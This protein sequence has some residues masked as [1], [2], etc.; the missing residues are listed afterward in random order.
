MNADQTKEFWRKSFTL[1]GKLYYPNL[2]KPTTNKNGRSTFNTMLAW[3]YD[4][5]KETMAALNNFL[6]T[7]KQTFHPSAPMQFFINPLKKFDTYQR[8]DGK[9]NA[10]YLRNCFWINAQSGAEI[11]VP[12]V[13]MNRQPVISEAEVYS[14]RN[15]VVNI[16]FYNIDKEKKGIGVNLNAVMLMPGG[17]RVGGGGSVNIDKIFG[18]FASDMAIPGNS[19]PPP[20]PGAG[21]NNPFGANGGGFI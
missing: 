18:G 2:F 10:E 1:Q 6:M 20:I 13:D 7:A 15:A 11:P 16:S 12:V 14:G 3:E 5:N 19:T 4:S 17:E 9:P 21:S 8:Q